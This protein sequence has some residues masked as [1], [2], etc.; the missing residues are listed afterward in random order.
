[1]GYMRAAKPEAS[2]A[3]D[4]V[5]TLADETV[6]LVDACCGLPLLMAGDASGFAHHAR[7]V[8]R[9][10]SGRDRVWVVDPGCAVAL[11]RHY[12]ERGVEARPAI[13]PLVGP[14]ART[15]RSLAP[16]TPRDEEEAEPVRWHDPCQLGRGLGLYDAPRLVL[17]RVLGRAP[18]ELPDR[19]ETALCSGA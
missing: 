13:G 4:A 17:T 18:E 5:T 11:K 1:C 19:R 16:S 6:A 12:V 15:L 7:E 9:T 2:D 3:I 10:L 8:A 14:P